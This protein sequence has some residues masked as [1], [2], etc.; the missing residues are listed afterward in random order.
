M[1]VVSVLGFIGLVCIVC[2]VLAGLGRAGARTVAREVRR[3]AD[4]TRPPAVGHAART[5]ADFHRAP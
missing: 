5:V 2:R 1:I 4:D 3:A